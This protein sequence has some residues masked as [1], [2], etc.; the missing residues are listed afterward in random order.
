MYQIGEA[1]TRAVARVIRSGQLFRYRGGEGGECDTFE[2]EL[3][4]KL[5]C[6]HSILVSGGTG[7]L[8]CGLV[9]LGVGPGDEVVV[10]AYTFMAS[11]VAVLAAGAVPV[12]AEVDDSLTL[13]PADVERKITRRTKAIMPVHMMGLPCDMSALRRI[14]RKRGVLIVEDACQ[15]VGGS[16]RKKRLGTIGDAGAMSFN[17]FKIVTCG[18]GGAVLTSNRDV[19]ERAL[20]HHDGG[21]TF[22]GHTLRNELFCGWGFRASEFQGAIMRPQLRRLDGI[23]KKL[24]ARKRA[25]VEA[26]KG[27][28]AYSL[29]PV[30]CRDGDCGVATAIRVG[31]ER[32]MRRAIDCVN[33]AGL[34]ASS[35]IDSG[36]HVYSNWT[37]ILKQRAAHHPKRNAFRLTPKKYRYTKTMCPRTTAVLSTTL[38][39]HTDFARSVAEHR[40]AASRARKLIE[41]L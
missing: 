3:C 27:S 34:H 30:R 26:L 31:S 12:V 14:A 39:L 38:F 6:R 22:R 32:A 2:K 9:G 36:M 15:A 1:E 20:I 13:D 35:P 21:A 8:I 18:E 23:L 37:P 24:R 29:S 16:Y 40:R 28:K 17:H 10:P 11:P 25:V 33:Q 41:A 19:F 5:G 4:R 7:A